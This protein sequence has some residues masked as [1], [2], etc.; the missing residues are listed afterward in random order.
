V[1]RLGLGVWLRTV[2][3]GQTRWEFAQIRHVDGVC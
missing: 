1:R 2:S 3:Y